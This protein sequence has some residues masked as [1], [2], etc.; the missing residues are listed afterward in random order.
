MGVNH[1]RIYL[2][3][4]QVSVLDF[5][6]FRIGPSDLLKTGV[7]IATYN[8]HLKAPSFPVVFCLQ[9][10]NTVS[11]G[12]FAFIQSILRVL[13]EGWESIKCAPPAAGCPLDGRPTLP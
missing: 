13:C 2:R 8:D 3:V 6:G 7:I 11:D 5:S 1:F 10:K 9:T 12:A 4:R